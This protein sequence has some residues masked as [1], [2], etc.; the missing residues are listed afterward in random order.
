[1]E[2]EVIYKGDMPDM[3]EPPN[4]A[5]GDRLLGREITA[6]KMEEIVSELLPI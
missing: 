1:V 2:V 4:I 3:P 6:E 5:V